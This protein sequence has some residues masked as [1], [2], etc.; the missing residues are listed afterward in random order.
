MTHGSQGTRVYLYDLF[1][2]LIIDFHPTLTV[3]GC[4]H[5]HWL[6]IPGFSSKES[7]LRFCSVLDAGPW[8]TPVRC[9]A[10]ERSQICPWFLSKPFLE[11]TALWMASRC[12][13]YA[14]LP[15][16]LCLEPISIKCSLQGLS[17]PVYPRCSL[18]LWLHSSFLSAERMSTRSLFSRGE[19][20][21]G[22]ELSI[23]VSHMV[24]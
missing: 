6:W 22:T 3:G 19:K 13:F 16:A 1:L 20:F 18:C 4:C 15:S 8:R 21:L 10:Q 12:I 14:F 17:L 23:H 2:G 11:L 5:S 9:W 24:S 7:S